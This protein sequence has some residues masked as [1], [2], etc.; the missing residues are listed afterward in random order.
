MQGVNWGRSGQQSD[1][2]CHE[3]LAG[4]MDAAERRGDPMMGSDARKSTSVGRVKQAA[5]PGFVGLSGGG[6]ATA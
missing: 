5:V 6:M 1:D 3:T 2:R 4:G